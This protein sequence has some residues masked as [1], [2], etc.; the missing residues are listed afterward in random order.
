MDIW[1][2]WTSCSAWFVIDDSEQNWFAELARIYPERT[3]ILAR[4]CTPC[5][6][7]TRRQRLAVEDDGSD[8]ELRCLDCGETLI[9][10]GRARELWGSKKWPPPLRCR[11]CRDVRQ[12]ALAAGDNV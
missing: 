5:R 4:S 10:G 3:V 1:K 9:F 11:P 2:T 8:Q 7:A 6:K 12:I